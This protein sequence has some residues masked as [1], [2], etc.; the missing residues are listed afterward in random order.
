M[1]AQVQ[2]ILSEDDSDTLG[3]RIG[4]ARSSAG[5]SVAQ[6][7]RRLGV[8]VTTWKA[9]ECDRSEPRSNRLVMMAG[10]LGVSPT[11]LLIGSGDGPKDTIGDEIQ[12]LK[13]ELASVTETI[14][15]AQTRLQ[16]IVKRLDTFTSFNAVEP[17]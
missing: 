10:F 13:L 3:G 11:W 2:E 16:Q 9:W 7:A 15:N 17:L 12:L 4:R 8:K 14:D 6:A 1:N 5:L